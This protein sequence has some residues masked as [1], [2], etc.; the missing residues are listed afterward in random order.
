MPLFCAMMFQMESIMAEL[1]KRK[2]ELAVS[3]LCAA[4]LVTAVILW[5]SRNPLRTWYEW[6]I[7]LCDVF[8]FTFIGVQFL[9]SW[10]DSW[11]APAVDLFGEKIGWQTDLKIFLGVLGV[12]AVRI[13]L[14]YLWA[15]MVFEYSGS[16]MDSLDI[17]SA[18]DTRHYLDIAEHWYTDYENIGTVWRLVFL[19][20]YSI[21]IRGA[22]LAVSDYLYAGILVSVLSSS[23]A[24]CVLYRLARL[25]YDH[26]TAAR[27][28]KYFAI[29]PAALFYTAA[30]S[31]GTFMLLS[32]AC[33]YMARKQ[34]WIGA[35]IA[36]GLAAFTRSTGII[37]LVPVCFEW[38]TQVLKGNP[39]R[40]RTTLLLGFFQ[41]L[42]PLGFF[43]YLLINYTET[44]DWFR[45][46]AYQRENWDQHLGW[47]FASVRYQLTYLV[48]WFSDRRGNDAIGL[49]LSGLLSQFFALGIMAVSA[50]K[51]RPSYTAYFLVYFMIA[52]GVT[53]LLSAPR[54]LL[55]LFPLL[56]A[57][58]DESKRRG[59]DAVLTAGC[60]LL[61][62]VYLVAFIGR[63]DVY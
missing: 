49:W 42:I 12:H 40:R 26:E 14:A 47:F 38:L 62:Q 61:G 11:R 32:L 28:V 44:G 13:L 54:Y 58:A 53:W 7:V 22:H 18:S 39:C 31:E 21:L 51:L 46:T 24:G 27:A 56:F 63:F 59:V 33:I 16:L 9:F 25:D 35:G 5:E 10:F 43:A 23:A 3:A 29:L 55:I 50:R 2:M 30:L 4:G 34:N 15:C 19:P 37:L 57:M 8:L 60:L 1:K 48:D 36:G 20:F 17:W 52:M 41:F 6:I 45:F